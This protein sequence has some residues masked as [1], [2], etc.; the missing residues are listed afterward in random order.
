MPRTVTLTLRDVPA[1]VARAL[2]DR[3]RRNGRSMQKELL[4]IIEGT[5]ADREAL[6]D[7]LAELRER[8][9]AKLRVAEIDAAIDEGR[10]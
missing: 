2:R 9:G 7:R 5:V 4:S 1:E 10:P 6:A 8:A 3:A